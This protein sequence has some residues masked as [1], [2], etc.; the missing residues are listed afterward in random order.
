LENK[1]NEGELDHGH[2]ALKIHRRKHHG[3]S[4]KPVVDGEKL[5]HMLLTVDGL[6][7]VP[8]DDDMLTEKLLPGCLKSEIEDE[9]ESR[10]IGVFAKI[11][12]IFAKAPAAGA[13]EGKAEE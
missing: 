8:E 6:H 1:V 5:K 7:T 11:R 9:E 12:A 13:E 10:W 3:K 4:I 2:L